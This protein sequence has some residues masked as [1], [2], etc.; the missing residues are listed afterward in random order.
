MRPFVT[1]CC[2][3]RSVEMG[4]GNLLL[5]LSKVFKFNTVTRK[6]R[7]SIM[8]TFLV[9]FM[10][11]GYLY[12]TNYAGFVSK[13]ET[14]TEEKVSTFVI[15]ADVYGGCR[16]TCPSFQVQHDGTYRYLYTPAAGAEQ[17]IKKGTLP[18]SLQL[19]LQMALTDAGLQRQAAVIQP[20]VCNSYTDGIDVRYEITLNGKEYQLNS[21]GTAVE[22]E[23]E[24][25]L[26]LAATWDQLERGGN[27]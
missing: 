22:A 27:I 19:R 18:R 10:I 6:D 23:S 7:L 3:K 15:V 13:L 12:L 21:C 11:G 8:I 2:G 26:S 17:V 25:W 1:H 20:G 5:C 24:L 14:P 9:G 4:Q 16:D